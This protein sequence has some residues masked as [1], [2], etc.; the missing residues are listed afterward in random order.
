MT[1][2]KS[3]TWKFALAVTVIFAV[4]VTAFI[5]KPSTAKAA[6]AAPAESEDSGETGAQ[7]EKTLLQC[8]NDWIIFNYLD[9]TSKPMFDIRYLDKTIE[10]LEADKLLLQYRT[11]YQCDEDF[12]LSV[13]P[14]YDSDAVVSEET[15][16]DIENILSQIIKYEDNL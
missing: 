3:L 7:E 4:L 1:K 8:S 13:S 11:I 14:W 12:E 6:D 9:E 5:C 2:E 10:E 16:T 15:K